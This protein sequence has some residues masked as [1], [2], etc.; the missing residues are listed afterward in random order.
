M[1]RLAERLDDAQVEALI[2]LLRRR[3]D[4]QFFP[5]TV[6]V[7]EDLATEREVKLAGRDLRAM[8]DHPSALDS[9]LFPGPDTP[10][11]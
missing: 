2:G 6:E 10:A 9:D 4:R 1:A 7:L 8:S 5:K 3:E 11:G